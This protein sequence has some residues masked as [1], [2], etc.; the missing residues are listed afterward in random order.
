MALSPTN[1]A[2]LLQ[3]VDE[4]VRKDQLDTIMQRYGRWILGGA[5]AALLA[6][7]GYLYWGHRQDVVRGEK[8]E[9]L[10]AAFDK[11]KSGQPT[12]A[13]AALKTLEG[14]GNPAYRAAALIEQSNLKAQTGDL[15]AA[16]A[17]MAKVATDTKLDQS[18]R[19]MALIRQTALEYDTLKPEAIVARLK[20]IVDA[21]DPVSSWFPSAAE[22]SAAAY[23]QQ[24]QYDQAG[25]LY[26]R[27]A[28]MPGVTKSLQSRAVQM[29][30]MLG[31]DAVADRAAESLKAD[32]ER[33]RA[34]GNTD[35]GDQ[36][37]A[38]GAAA[39]A[40]SEEAK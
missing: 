23:Y 33:V 25:K 7:G 30:G 40:K 14:E 4:A 3:E 12:A 31:V 13:T 28:K 18:L 38:P 6:F 9:E 2:A 16:A 24:G 11:V 27:I 34:A 32:A 21:K 15:K 5:V 19:D 1:D 20:P 29:A 37:G 8:A 10:L 35:N 22:L 36:K 26:G 17:L 39:A